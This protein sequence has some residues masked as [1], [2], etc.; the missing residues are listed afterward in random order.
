MHDMWLCT[1]VCHHAW[2]CE[3]F[4]TTC[5]HCPF[6]FSKKR[7][8]LSYRIFKKKQFLSQSNIHIVTVSS[9]LKTM[10]TQSV[11]T[12]GLSVSVIPN[13][14][15]VS[16]FSPLNKQ[17]A[18]NRYSLPQ[19]KKII[20]MG[21]AKIDDPIKG[22]EYL[23]QALLLL[24]EKRNDLFL[25]LF[26]EIKGGN[27][28]LSDMPI[29]YRSL[30]LLSEA[31]SIAQLYACSDVTVVPSFY[32]TFGQTLIESMA[33]GCPAVSFDNSGQT[34]IIDHKINGYLA[35][36]KD[37]EDLATG[38]EWVLDN[39]EKSHLSEAC[40]KKVQENYTES[41]VAGQYIDLYKVLVA[42]KKQ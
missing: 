8:D 6:L 17:E 11:I 28:F 41:I 40:I 37:A 19:G 3:K 5:G 2:G 39:T 14:I 24:K 12:K 15:D 21:A 1:G 32:E 10:A 9:W 25:I 30:G 33:C 23:K 13:T 27:S 42:N 16:V 4:K 22:F 7:K 20:L 29:E 35:K 38:I 18:R 26:G 34:D 36:Y 31:S